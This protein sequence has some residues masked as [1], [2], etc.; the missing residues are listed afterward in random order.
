[1]PSLPLNPLRLLASSEPWLALVFMISSFVVGLCW[2]IVLVTL[3]ATGGG[4][5]ITLIGLPIL[6]GTMYLWIGGAKLERLRVNALL[7]TKIRDPYKPIPAGTSFW[8]HVWM[9]MKDGHT[10]LDLLYLFLLF[11]IGL[12][13]FV[14]ATVV[15]SV[16]F[17]FIAVPIW[18]W[19]D[20]LDWFGPDWFW[21]IDT[22]VEAF[23]LA[24]IGIPLLLL[25][26]Y[27]LV[28]IGRGHAHLA[29]ALL[30]TNR[31]AE[32]T[33]RVDH[34][35]AS[36]TK[37]VDVSL[38]ERR[39]IERDL[40]DGAQQQLV[41]L[42]MDLGMAREKM[43]SDPEAAQALVVEAH[44]ESKRALVEIRNLVRGI[45][46]AVL[47]DRGLDAAVSALAGRST[48]PVSVDVRLESRP[49]EAIESAAYFV[50]AEA[51]TNIARH[52]Q[53]D[54][55]LVRIYKLGSRLLV[56]IVD[57][58]VGGASISKGTGLAGLADRVGALDGRLT[59]DSPVGGP[60]TVRA[61]LPLS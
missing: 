12:A 58:G 24:L 27:V 23:G 17:Q 56:E 54:E 32:L 60:T 49:S 48:I 5:A 29:K 34:L 47:T 46:P 4:L 42:A 37:A 51:L 2:F 30:G 15:V 14:I 13:E 44:E 43:E 7:G 22:V 6:V 9:R 40:H 52:S 45:H 53:A 36:R 41:K 31:E 18:Y 20:N 57:N 25:M 19:T 3:L 8:G 38:S 1:R 21:N 35:T 59:V 33:Q 61:D 16:P 10:W 28:G 55:A 26:P 39:R 11:P 50:V